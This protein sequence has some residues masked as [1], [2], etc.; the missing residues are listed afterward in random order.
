MIVSVDFISSLFFSFLF[1]ISTIFLFLIHIYIYISIRSMFFLSYSLW[2]D[3][4][5]VRCFKCVLR[6]RREFYHTGT[7]CAIYKI[8]FWREGAHTH[9][10]KTNSKCQRTQKKRTNQFINIVVLVECE[11]K[12]AWARVRIGFEN[13][14]LKSFQ[15]TL[16]I[17]HRECIQ[18]GNPYTIYVHRYN[19]QAAT[20]VHTHGHNTHITDGEP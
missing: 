3:P 11:C 17:S 8:R 9:I 13:S 2:L 19:T 18:S 6:D 20:R 15:R 10:L 16:G 4:L 12:R 14:Q 1:L 7:C 5:S